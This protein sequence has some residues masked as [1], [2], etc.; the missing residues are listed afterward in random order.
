MGLFY[1][2]Y[3]S[4]LCVPR[5]RARAPGVAAVGPASLPG[6]ALRWH[7]RS[8]D[9]S[10]KC[11]IVRSTSPAAEVHGALFRVPVPAKRLLDRV[12]GLGSGYRETTVR[13]RAREWTSE[14]LTYIATPSHV[15]ES[16]RPYS[17]Y[18]DL[19]VS[20]AVA[21]GLPADYVDELRGV[22]VWDDRDAER[23]ARN[24]ACLPC[25]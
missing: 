10:G 3:G 24:L 14:A 19:V 20:G 8:V 7:K 13:L 5:L 15:D 23:A 16:L 21:H 18:K 2:A 6:Y 4:N 11:S 12:E 22:A 25:S 9:G 17:W 1:F